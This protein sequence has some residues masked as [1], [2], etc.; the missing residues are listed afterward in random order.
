M[1]V[2]SNCS[3]EIPDNQPKCPFCGAV[4]NNSFTGQPTG[5]SQP[6]YGQPADPAYAQPPYGQAPV[7]PPYQQQYGQTVQQ[8]DQL[9]MLIVCFFLGFLGIHRFLT[10]KIVSG[11]FMILTL[12]GLGIW[13]LIDYILILLGKFNDKNGY[14][15]KKQKTAVIVGW[16]LLG[17]SLL[18]TVSS[19]IFILI[20]LSSGL[21]S[22]RYY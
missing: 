18:V 6:P 9:V 12:G 14:P 1:P 10:G 7:Y 21:G 8:P 20:S 11:V 19:I 4:Q 17:L 16:V 13:T 5:P 2:C 22:P 3:K 15:I